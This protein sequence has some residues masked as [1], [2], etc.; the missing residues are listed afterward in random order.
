MEFLLAALSDKANTLTLSKTEEERAAAAA[1][2]QALADHLKSV[3]AGQ[4]LQS[5]KTAKELEAMRKEQGEALNYLI[6]LQSQLDITTNQLESTLHTLAEVEQEKRLLGKKVDAL[7]KENRLI[8]KERS[9]LQS[10]LDEETG[11]YETLSQNWKAKEETLL[12]TIKTQRRA[13]RDMRAETATLQRALSPDA[14]GLNDRR[15]SSNIQEDVAMRIL[16]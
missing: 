10:R 9:E 6:T 11:S 3:A 13:T 16:K 1:S 4:K 7:T 14:N 2:I 8:V 15:R 5:D 12:D